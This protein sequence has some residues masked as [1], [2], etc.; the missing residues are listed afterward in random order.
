MIVD[1]VE[2]QRA[3]VVAP[4]AA[5]EDAVVTRAFFQVAGLLA[6]GQ[7]GQQVQRGDAL[8]GGGDI[9][10]G[11]FDGLDRDGCD[12]A[13]IHRASGDG[14]AVFGDLVILEDPVHGRQVELR[15]H[16]HHG[17]VFVV[18]LVVLVVV[19]RLA[20][21]D[22]DDLVLE[23]LGMGFAIHRDE[24]GQLQQAGI[25]LA[26]DTGVFEADALD[27]GVFE[28][29]HGDTVAEIGDFGRGGAGV[30]GATDQGQ[31]ARLGV[32]F[33]LCQIGGGGQGQRRWL[34]DR[35][36]MCVRAQMLHEIDKVERVI[37]DIE[38]ACA[39]GNVAG[40]VPV[41]DIDVTIGQ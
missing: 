27:H 37:L 39:D 23:R 7:A 8:A 40:I 21:G 28:L 3:N 20:A 2:H 31:G 15:R 41:G 11:A 14:K 24:G 30:D 32:G 22:A 18:E 19:V 38:L 26:S 16:V 10:L 12:L 35:D 6:V 17:K 4:A 36:H 1:K 13:D 25:D 9:V 34:A 5:R 29:P 33:F